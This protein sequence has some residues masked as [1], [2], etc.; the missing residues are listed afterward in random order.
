[1]LRNLERRPLRALLSVTGIALAMAI[2]MTGWFMFDAIDV[3][4]QIQFEAVQR[5]DVMVV[6][7]VPR[8]ADAAWALGRIDGVR[9]VEPFRAVPVRLRH[10]RLDKR[11]AILGLDRAA[12][13]S[14]SSTATSR[15]A[16]CRAEGSLSPTSWRRSSGWWRATR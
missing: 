10:G 15:C 6:F 16:T 5:H 3:M 7:D 8:S 14:G 1:M 13:C 9:K 2:V 11:A 4:K 12:N